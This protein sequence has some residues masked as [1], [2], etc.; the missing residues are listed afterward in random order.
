[1]DK[2]RFEVAAQ[3]GLSALIGVGVL[4]GS[5]AILGDVATSTGLAM[6]GGMVFGWYVKQ[7][8]A[9]AEKAIIKLKKMLRKAFG[10]PAEKP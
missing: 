4:I 10:V 5:F 9:G 3:H 8:D 6:V 7:I 2:E 1:M